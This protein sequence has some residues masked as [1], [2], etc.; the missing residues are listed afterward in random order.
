MKDVP[1]LLCLL[2]LEDALNGCRQVLV[3]MPYVSMVLVF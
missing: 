3:L 2:L 1:L